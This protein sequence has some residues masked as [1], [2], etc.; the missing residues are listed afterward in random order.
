[1]TGG[2]LSNCPFAPKS[3]LSSMV[4]SS[5]GAGAVPGRVET[6]A[7]G[8][9]GPLAA[10]PDLDLLCSYYLLTVLQSTGN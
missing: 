7:T 6:N 8:L 1:M 2:R 10:L 5:H 9:H 3:M 4:H